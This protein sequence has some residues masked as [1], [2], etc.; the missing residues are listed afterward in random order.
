MTERRETRDDMRK[1]ERR[2]ELKKS[3]WEREREGGLSDVIAKYSIAY[4]KNPFTSIIY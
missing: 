3:D 1:E 4:Q 2:E